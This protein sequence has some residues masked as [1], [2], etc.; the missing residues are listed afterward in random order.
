M[1]SLVRFFSIPPHGWDAYLGCNV[2]VVRPTFDSL[3]TVYLVEGQIKWHLRHFTL[4]KATGFS[5]VVH[6]LCLLMTA[7]S[8]HPCLLNSDFAKT[9][10]TEMGLCR[11]KAPGISVHAENA[12][13]TVYKVLTRSSTIYWKFTHYTRKA[14]SGWISILMLL[15]I[16]LLARRFKNT[17]FGFGR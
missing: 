6:G 1:R 3:T 11:L 7:E 5:L 10:Y 13:C 2:V 9:E 17:I 12:G 8:A 14:V 15:F 16:V 4:K